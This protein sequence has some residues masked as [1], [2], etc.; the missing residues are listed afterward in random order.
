MEKFMYNVCDL[1]SFFKN[2]PDVSTEIKEYIE[3]SFKN[4]QLKTIDSNTIPLIFK[5]ELL[6]EIK[7]KL[8]IKNEYFNYILFLF[9]KEKLEYSEINKYEDYGDFIIKAKEEIEK[10]K[11]F[12]NAWNSYEIF[13]FIFFNQTKGWDFKEYLLKFDT[14]SG[15]RNFFFLMFNFSGALPYLKISE[16]ILT[17]ILY[18]LFNQANQDLSFGQVL[19]TVQEYSHN[20]ST[21][22]WKLVKYMIRNKKT[23]FV[24]SILVGLSKVNFDKTFEYTKQLFYKKD[25]SGIAIYT[26]GALECEDYKYLEEILDLFDSVESDEENILA[27]LAKSYGYLVHKPLIQENGKTDYLF[28]KL[29]AL[30]KKEMPAVQYNILI[31]IFRQ[32]KQIYKEKKIELL[33][34]FTKVDKKYNGIISEIENALNTLKE[35]KPILKFIENWVLNHPIENYKEIFSYPLHG[36]YNRN[37]SEFIE[38]YLSLLI[39]NKGKIRFYANNNTDFIQVT[40]KNK[41]I[42]KEHLWKLDNNQLI[43]FINS[44]LSDT[45]KPKERMKLVLILL[46]KKDKKIFKY[47]LQRFVW[48]VYDYGG[49]VKE[50]VETFLDKQN[51]FEK[52]FIDS[53]L[54]CYGK[55]VNF[56]KIKYEIKEFDPYESQAIYASKFDK[57][58]YK[59]QGEDLRKSVAE[60]SVFMKLCTKIAISRGRKFKIGMNDQYSEMNELKTAFIIPRTY[61]IFPELYDFKRRQILTDEREGE[62]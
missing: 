42:W 60:H 18:H 49:T 35:P 21:D 48:L 3:A 19:K 23:E 62:L 61:F 33:M 14:K 16:E 39:H 30:A 54:I 9:L 43:K 20:Q 51:P 24:V 25:F 6:E 22:G 52:K 29:N 41:E 46:N 59:K 36:A 56:W 26:F 45:F 57:L 11:P 4:G 7:G 50:T 34:K 17:E 31:S 44:I 15:S 10:L 2:N 32:E 47:I 58:F 27:A 13:M 8:L 37:S 28:E 38:N 40:E 55:I 5:F 53:F 1:I 12:F